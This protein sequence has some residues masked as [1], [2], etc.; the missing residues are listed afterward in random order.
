MKYFVA[1]ARIRKRMTIREL[2]RRSGVAKSH[3][4]R[5]EA[6]QAKPSLEVMCQL[7]EALD[8]PL[9][10]LFEYKKFS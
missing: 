6:G 7:A 3:I 2:S 10:A 8:E 9:T 1:E 5:I 4:Q